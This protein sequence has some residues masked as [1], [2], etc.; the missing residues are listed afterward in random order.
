MTSP[1]AHWEWHVSSS[2]RTLSAASA[3][4]QYPLGLSRLDVAL[5]IAFSPTKFG[6]H[7]WPSPFIH[8]MRTESVTEQRSF[9]A[10]YVSSS[11][12]HSGMQ[13]S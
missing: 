6:A 11:V 3:A 1:L 4:Y 13:V 2:A 9:D 5:L 7:V 8:W 10:W 12:A